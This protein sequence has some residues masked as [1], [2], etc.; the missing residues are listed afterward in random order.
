MKYGRY[1]AVAIGFSILFL[2]LGG[3][4]TTDG[5]LREQGRGESYI[6][7]FHDGRHSGMKEAGNYLEHIVRDIQRFE[8]DADYKATRNSHLHKVFIV[9]ANQVFASRHISKSVH[10]EKERAST[11]YRQQSP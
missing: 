3:C 10:C 9:T 8:D 11:L 1:L 7:G 6:T 2:V 4:G 5:A